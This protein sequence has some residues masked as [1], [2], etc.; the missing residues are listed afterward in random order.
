MRLLD[1]PCTPLH[2]SICAG[3][4]NG[5]SGAGRKLKQTLGGG[6]AGGVVAAD[7]TVLTTPSGAVA[8]QTTTTQTTRKVGAAVTTTTQTTT[9]TATVAKQHAVAGG[10]SSA[11]ATAAQAAAG[12]G[13]DATPAA[14]AAPATSGGPAAAFGASSLPGADGAVFYAS[15]HASGA[16]AHPQLAL[17]YSTERQ[18]LAIPEVCTQSQARQLA[19]EFRR[20]LDSVPYYTACGDHAWLDDLNSEHAGALSHTA[21]VAGGRG[22]QAG[23]NSGGAGRICSRTWDGMSCTPSR[24]SLS[25]ELS[26]RGAKVMMDVGCNKGYSSAKMFGLWAPE[27]GFNPQAIPTRRPE[28]WCGN[29]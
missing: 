7:V 11:A 22:S 21:G 24:P 18:G 10:G 14:P 15:T 28:V 25:P 5:E 19:A 29:W 20:L 9:T 1:C 4:G 16:R 17:H 23:S 13:A 3:Y 2:V 6:N 27:L 8:T 26:P 12:E